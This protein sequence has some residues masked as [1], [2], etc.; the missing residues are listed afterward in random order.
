MIDTELT[1]TEV[2]ETPK[3]RNVSPVLLSFV[4][5]LVLAVA[6][7]YYVHLKKEKLTKPDTIKA[8]NNQNHAN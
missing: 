6:A 3:S 2:L 8:A 1:D 7:G 5:A 4:I